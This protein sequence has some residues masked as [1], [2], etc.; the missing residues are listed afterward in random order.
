MCLLCVEIQK[1]NLSIREIASNFNEL[2]A[3]D[4]HWVDVLVEI[5]KKGIIEEVQLELERMGVV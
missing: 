2:S 5:N 3:D 1:D 4:D